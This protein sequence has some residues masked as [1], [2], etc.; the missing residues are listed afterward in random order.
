MSEAGKRWVARVPSNY[1]GFIYV[2][3]GQ[4]KFG[5]TEVSAKQGDVLMLPPSNAQAADDVLDELVV[6]SETPGVHF[7]LFAGKP[8]NE[9]VFARGPFVMDSEEGLMQAFQD[10]RRGEKYFIH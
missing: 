5:I 3:S 9:P 10:F 6:V 7:V 4:A 8:I 1:N 2:M